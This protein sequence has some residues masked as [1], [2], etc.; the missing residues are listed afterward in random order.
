MGIKQMRKKD[1]TNKNIDLNIKDD[2]FDLE[3]PSA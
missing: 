1:K 2:D 3:F